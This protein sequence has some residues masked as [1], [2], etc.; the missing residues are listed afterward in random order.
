M[1]KQILY[2]KPALQTIYFDEEDVIKTSNGVN[3]GGTS[4]GGNVVPPIS[5]GGNYGGEDY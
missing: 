2:K 5:N 3:G 4:G 1:K